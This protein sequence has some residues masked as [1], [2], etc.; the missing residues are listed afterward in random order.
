MRSETTRGCIFACSF[1]ST[2]SPGT[3]RT[4]PLGQS[5]IEAELL[6][7]A[8]GGVLDVAFPRPRLQ[9]RTRAIETLELIH[10]TCPRARFSFQCH[11]ETLTPDFLDACTG[12]DVRLEFGLQTIQPAEMRAV[13]RVNRRDR[14]E[15]GIAELHRRGIP[16]EVSLIYGL[17][18]Q[19][20]ETFRANVAFCKEHRVPVLR[21]FPLALL[22]GTEV[23]RDRE[24][25][26][27]R[28]TED[29]IQVVCESHTFREDAWQEMRRLAD[30]V[31]RESGGTA[32]LERP[33][34]RVPSVPCGTR[35]QSLS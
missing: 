35:V 15:R 28:E 22:H 33:G 7:S 13:R 29:E 24:R 9:P 18:E 25:W 21:A 12:L 31:N 5:L 30:E 20:L 23:H 32:G 10:R 16:F 4:R 19:T 26:G 17:P 2:T 34:S 14:V 11:F 8:R 6:A 1:C 27:F 3:R